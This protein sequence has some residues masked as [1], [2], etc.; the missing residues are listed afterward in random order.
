[1]TDLKLPVAKADV[2]PAIPQTTVSTP[3][4]HQRG[5]PAEPP[6]PRS[7]LV[8]WL[9]AAMLGAFA[10]WA[11]LF[12]L[13][14]V[15]TGSGKVVPS[16]REQVIQSLEG[17]ILV[18]LNV[19]EGDLVEAGQVLA[20]LDRTR[21]ESAVEESASRMRAAKAEAARLYAEVNGTPLNFPE[22]VQ[23]FPDLVSSETALYHSR[24]DSLAKNL[25]GINDALGLVRR[26]L[27]M[28]QPLVARG[29]ASDVEVLRLRRQAN[30]LERKATELQTQYVVKARE[31][32]ARANAEIEAQSSVTRGRSDA[33]HR[34][35]FTSPVRGIVKDIA[36]TTVGG[37]VPQDGKLMEIVPVDEKLLVEAHISP[38]DVAFIRPGLDATVKITAYDYSIYGGLHGKVTT[39]S[40]DTIQDE[41]KREV[42]YYRVF[43][44][45]D[46]DHLTN[47]DGKRFDIVPGMIAT[48]DI[49]T[50]N[51][52]I[53]DYLL[54]PLNKA[55]E[56]LRER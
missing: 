29:A 52:T 23:A 7:S 1:M 38:R 6:L 9:I 24:K 51:K 46:V 8:V 40:P 44:R 50:G 49:H 15:S 32:L 4:A 19:H 37:V 55:R 36:V 2:P 16:S 10:V 39:I 56:A 5:A 22:D 30:E 35:T 48:V 27:A 31:D 53:L 45:T 12:S 33:L 14:E 13:D 43:I 21:S 3:R 34:T 28:T 41:V 47:K 42:F 11:S 54:K 20:Q 26:E 17:G 25:A 18:S